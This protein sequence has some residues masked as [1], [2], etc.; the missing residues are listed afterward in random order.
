MNLYAM[1]NSKK[2]GNAGENC[3]ANWLREHGITAHR[4]ASSGANIVKSDV[5]NGIDA[6]FE[7]KTVKKLNLQEAWKQSQRDAGNYATPYVI[8][9]F[10]GMAPDRCL[11]VLDNYD[12][13]VLQW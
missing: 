1:L 7:V 5:V 2:K 6:N 13:L 3:R 4:N 9:H 8:I 10:D 12:W 11:V